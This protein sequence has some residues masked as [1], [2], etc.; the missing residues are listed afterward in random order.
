MDDDVIS[1][2]LCLG[3]PA[4]GEER[5]VRGVEEKTR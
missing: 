1:F 4:E 2:L 5:A 3:K